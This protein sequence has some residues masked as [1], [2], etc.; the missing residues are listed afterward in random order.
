M[1]G[2][3]W[4]L[5]VIGVLVLLGVAWL[6]L[7]SRRT[8][9]LQERFGPEYD[10]AL[11]DTDSKRRAEEE[12]RAREKRR[13]QLDIRPLGPAARE[14]YAESWR[15]V[16]TRF[17]D[18]P[19]GAAGDA[20]RL[21]LEVMRERGYPIDDFDQRAADLSVDHAGVVEHYRAADRIARAS[22]RGEATTEDLRQALVHYRALFED[23]LETRETAKEEVR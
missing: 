7:R 16:Q 22:E 2:W 9:Q 1:P 3:A 21:V 15:T 23:L 18:D 19:E 14:R 6:A 10:Q 8:A 12:L 11:E 20:H 4:V 5:V 13:E 17:V